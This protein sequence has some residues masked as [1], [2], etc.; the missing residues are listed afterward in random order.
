LECIEQLRLYPRGLG[1]GFLFDI[2]FV[3]EF[4]LR[5]GA[6]N[7][8]PK[9]AK[10]LLEGGN[11][12]ML[13]PGGIYEALVTRP[14]IKRIPW[15]RRTGFVRTAVEAKVPIIP[16]Y[17]HG[18]DKVYFNSQFLL[19]Q[20]I[21]L[22]EKSRFSMPLFAGIGLLPFPA[23]LTHYIG[24][25][26]SPRKKKGETINQTVKRVHK[27]VLAEMYRLKDQAL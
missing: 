5:G 21:K 2:P 4:F 14:G 24:R 22:L 1:A 10:K 25:P 26:I 15:E 13:S 11:C 8:N 17:G 27:R 7:A 12:V 23:K 9:N 20:R 19:R 18:I 16:T 3:R 6:V